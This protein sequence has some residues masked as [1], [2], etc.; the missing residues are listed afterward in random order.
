LA[1]LGNP[2]VMTGKVE[3]GF[4]MCPC[5]GKDAAAVSAVSP[6]G[7]AL[8]DVLFPTETEAPV[9]SFTG[10][11]VDFRSINDH[12]QGPVS[13]WLHIAQKKGGLE[14]TPCS[15]LNQDR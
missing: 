10:T 6:V 9:A 4:D 13:F 15:G 14:T 7:S 2:I 5:D 12:R 11:N 1:I 3:K 8:G